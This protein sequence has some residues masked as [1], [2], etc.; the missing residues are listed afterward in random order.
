MNAYHVSSSYLQSLAQGLKAC[1]WHDEI[2]HQLANETKEAIDRPSKER[3]WPVSIS[4]DVIGTV[5]RL[6]LEH[7]SWAKSGEARRES[8]VAPYG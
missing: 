3:W 7:G 2:Q 8:Q 4:I 5:R 1:G 6:A